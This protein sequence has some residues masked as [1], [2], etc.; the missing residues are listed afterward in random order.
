MDRNQKQNV[1]REKSITRISSPEDLNE[2]IRVSNAGVWIMLI[3]IIIFLVGVI[4]WAIFG[5]V[6]SYQDGSARVNGGV[7]VVNYVHSQDEEAPT[8][9]KIQG[10]V[11]PLP[12]SAQSTSSVLK[13]DV[14]LEDGTYDCRVITRQYHPISFVLN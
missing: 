6:Y 7:A 13:F 8:S 11:Y 10:T 2:Y 9:V 14:L 12:E 3:A 4:I 1:F 5:S